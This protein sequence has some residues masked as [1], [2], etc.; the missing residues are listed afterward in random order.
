MANKDIELPEYLD[1]GS[2]TPQDE[3]EE[4]EDSEFDDDDYSD[5]V[6]E[7]FEVSRAPSTYRAGTLLIGVGTFLL[8]VGIVMG[9]FMAKKPEL[10]EGQ[11]ATYGISPGALLL[12]GV[13]LLTLGFTHRKNHRFSTESILVK[14]ED[15]LDTLHQQFDELLVERLPVNDAPAGSALQQIQMAMQKSEGM[16]SNLNKATRMFNK[17]LLDLVGK[18]T[19]LEKAQ[20][21]AE[22]IRTKVL[23]VQADVMKAQKE[24]KTDL[25][26]IERAMQEAHVTNEKKWEGLV[27]RFHTDTDG[28]AETV[29]KALQ[30]LEVDEQGLDKVLDKLEAIMAQLESAGDTAPS[31]SGPLDSHRLTRIETAVNQL[32]ERGGTAAVN[33]TAAPPPSAPEPAVATASAPAESSGKASGKPKQVMSAIERLKQLRGG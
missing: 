19:D 14:I 26:A 17:P 22:E 1:D 3:L 6:P 29:K 27:S 20:H 23:D 25:L 31:A 28:L 9:A 11:W 7:R 5:D 16:L 33:T 2:E 12:G 18:V 8:V 21:D 10:L 4:R 13:L 24:I 30:E 32:L 15:E